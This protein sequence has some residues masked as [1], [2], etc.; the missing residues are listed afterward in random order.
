M[1][2]PFG[3]ERVHQ[4]PGATPLRLLDCNVSI[5]R[6]SGTQW[7]PGSRITA[8][9]LLTEMDRLGIEG[10]VVH[11]AVAR[12][13]APAVGNALLG[14]EIDTDP[15]LSPCWL[16][17][18][19]HTGEFDDPATAVERMRASGVVMARM[20]PSTSPSAHRFF[21]APWVIGA[22]AE[23]L[24]AADIPLA[25]DF[26]LFRRAEPPWD[27]LHRLMV[28][29][30]ALRIVLM[31]IQGRNNRTLYPLLEAFPNLLVQSAGLNVH[32]GI[33]DVVQ[34][35][36]AQRIVFGSGFPLRSLGAA[37]FHLETAEIA[38]EDKQMIGFMNLA[39]VLPAQ[40]V[41]TSGAADGS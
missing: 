16:V 38:D 14:E 26:S 6:A 33:E 9:R 7:A 15:R 18:P 5:G 10:G 25:L 12:E 3:A 4:R 29:H 13:Y 36:G 39:S 27:Q 19:H 17:L 28:D 20:H 30:P 40:T 8:A 24:A 37:R 31:D 2:L 23:A 11:H 1:N 32:R 34:R 41:E 35:F 21:L 22:M